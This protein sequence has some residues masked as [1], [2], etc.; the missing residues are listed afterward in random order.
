M[1]ALIQE[2]I[3]SPYL[4]TEK[5][6]FKKSSSQNKI[7]MLT[8]FFK[9]CGPILLFFVITSNAS[10]QNFQWAKAIGGSS[11]D[12]GYHSAIDASGN[13]Y[14]TGTF[15]GV[16]DF[17]PGAGTAILT[18][19][20]LEDIFILKSDA[21]GNFLWVKQIGNTGSDEAY[22]ISENAGNLYITGDFSNTVDFDPGAS[23]TYLSSAGAT[24]VFI[25]KLDSSGNLIWARSVGGTGFEYAYSVGTDGSGNIYVT[26]YFLG[27][28]DF[29]P[30]AGTAYLTSAGGADIFFSKLDASGNFVWAKS[31]GGT[32]DDHGK[33]VIDGSGNIYTTGYFYGTVDF[34]PSAGVTYLTSSGM[35]DVSVFKL[36]AS[37]NFIWAKPVGGVNDD[38]AYDIVV[39][40][41]GNVYSTGSYDGTVDFDPGAGTYNLTAV[42]GGSDIFIFKLDPAGSFL[43]AKSMGGSDYDYS[44]GIAIDAASNVY[45]TGNF[46]GTADFDPSPGTFNLTSVPTS[47]ANEF[48]VKLDASGS[49][50]WAQAVNGTSSSY[51]NSVIVDA[52]NNVYATGYFQGTADFD[53]GTGTTNLTSGGSDD[54]F[55]LKLDQCN[56]VASAGTSATVCFGD[57]ATLNGSA[58]GGTP[59]Y[60]Y[61]WYDG[62]TVYNTPTINVSPLTSGGYTLT[63]TDGMCTGAANTNVII[64]PSRDIAGN[65]SFSG[66]AVA[67]SSIVLYAYEPF[68]A[69]FD[70]V[71][72]GTT[73]GSGNFFF[74]AVNHG[75]YLMEVY[76]SAS[77]TSLI[78]TYYGNQFLWD[79][80]AIIIHG[81]SVNDTLNIS[82]VEDSVITG[83]GF[84]HGTI[85]EDAGF[86]SPGDPVPGV[87]VKLGRN[88]G[89]QLV[90]S[91]Q[92]DSSGSYT[93]S[94]IGYGNYTIYVDIPGLERDS[95]YTLT[96]DT[97]HTVFNYLDYTVDSTTIHYVPNAGVG[98]HTSEQKSNFLV[99]PNPSKG[100]ATI[101]YTIT[102]ESEVNLGIYN[103]LGV[104]V[105]DLL[106]GHQ[107]TGTYKFIFSD[108]N[109]RLNSGV[110]FIALFTNGKTKIQ[111]IIISE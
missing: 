47:Y 39:D 82:C 28:A 98:I 101:E 17:D 4:Q 55:L 103:I 108:K 94:S 8:Q 21:S 48:I 85:L 95:S 89:G 106:S 49:F 69:H 38:L 105:A 35:N 78:P 102:T 77:Y 59:P 12:R 96:I 73:D 34:D 43:W 93:F 25:L 46:A 74:N 50:L 61:S 30:S 45:V 75:Q 51:G 18:S 9:T 52:S 80:A 104:K 14:T 56:L 67:G 20:G 24:D 88:P 29:D 87:D 86:R 37:G 70:T 54:I 64:I 5:Q 42:P 60:T 26:G 109:V 22:Y 83:P 11:S 76:P 41:A 7:I 13:V 63:V 40:P 3:L 110:Y 111:K 107:Q 62:V 65:V 27:T 100:N 23:S 15:T 16:V 53:G 1:S 6:K 72:T 68:L 57:T 92:T 10:A 66:G 19:A 91:T 44:N 97:T 81:C 99:Y 32:Y 2:F 31:V 71:Q 90:T 79:S 33:S 58:T 36:D 84:L